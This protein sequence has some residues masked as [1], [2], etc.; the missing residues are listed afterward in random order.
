MNHV[1]RGIDPGQPIV[2]PPEDRSCG[3]GDWLCGFCSDPDSHPNAPQPGH[4]EPWSV[5]CYH[6]GV[7]VLTSGAA[8][9]ELDKCDRALA[10]HAAAI[11]GRECC[12]DTYAGWVLEQ[13][14]PEQAGAAGD[15]LR[16]ALDLRLAY[17][18]VPD[19]T[20]Y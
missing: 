12:G 16:A 14:W 7:R 4:Y 18:A 15:C 17:P 6:A 9:G 1:K 19:P 20:F 11:A 10:W 2:P 8:W 13:R 3:F 5:D